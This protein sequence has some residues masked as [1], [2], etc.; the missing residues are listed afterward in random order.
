MSDI[1]AISDVNLWQT[2]ELNEYEIDAESE[3]FAFYYPYVHQEPIEMSTSGRYTLVTTHLDHGYNWVVCE[4]LG[5]RDEK[6]T[7][8]DGTIKTAEIVPLRKL[9]VLRTDTNSEFVLGRE[10][11]DS[12]LK[13]INALFV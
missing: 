7:I 4:S 8:P 5:K 9:R 10:R 12:I 13:K 6:Y 3:T 11:T 1:W 2:N